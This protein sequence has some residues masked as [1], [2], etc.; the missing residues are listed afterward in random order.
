MTDVKKAV[1]DTRE[2]TKTIKELIEN[3][4]KNVSNTDKTNSQRFP[5]MKYPFRQL[6][7]SN[8]ANLEVPT[9]GELCLI[10][11]CIV[12]NHYMN[13]TS[14]LED[15]FYVMICIHTINCF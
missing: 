11:F 7:K 4:T 8:M 2:D 1:E 10:C 5:Q 13:H 9:H 6:M 12:F 15:N 14:S 3:L